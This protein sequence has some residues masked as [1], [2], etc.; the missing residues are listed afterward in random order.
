MEKGVQS[1][2]PKTLT[3][4]CGA[5]GLPIPTIE[6]DEGKRIAQKLIAPDI[7]ERIPISKNQTL[8]EIITPKGFIKKSLQSI[9]LRK[10]LN[11]NVI[12]IKRIKTEIDNMGNP[13]KEEQIITPGPDVL[14]E[15][16]DIL[17]VVG[18]N[19]D[20]DSLKSI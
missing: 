3:N 20:I 18:S 15:E 5:C 2:T 17:V 4:R 1:D 6:I 9:A 8:A 13:V 7:L 14:L 19:P 16:N 11:I 10:K 12:S